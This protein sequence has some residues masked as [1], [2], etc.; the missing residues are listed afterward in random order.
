MLSLGAALLALAGASAALE[1]AMARGNGRAAAFARLRSAVDPKHDVVL[2]AD[3]ALDIV[4]AAGATPVVPSVGV[5]GDLTGFRRAFTV[6][7]DGTSTLPWGLAV[8]L[9]S[10][11]QP[12]TDASRVW[13]LDGMHGVTLDL[14]RDL[15]SRARVRREGGVFDGVCNSD[16]AQFRC[17][18]PDPWNHVRVEP[19]LVDGQQVQCIFAH[20][21]AGST[22]VIE[23]PSVPASRA[24]VGAA[25]LDDTAVFPGGADVLNEIRFE[26]D[27]GGPSRATLLRRTN[28]RGPEP[29]RLTLDERP[30]TLSFRI[31]TANA[32]ARVYC[33]TALFTR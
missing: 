33:F 13:Q 3:D 27:G 18:S 9:G 24:V 20:P 23:V 31:T 8:R 21:Q 10:P 26:P 28:N 29:Y 30:G 5:P 32:G 15:M 17:N 7:A 22:L 14:V 1:R 11:T 4:R 16:G 25:A 2:L 12:S 19:R 6:L